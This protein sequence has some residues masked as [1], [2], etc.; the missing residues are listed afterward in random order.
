MRIATFLGCILI[1]G[2]CGTLHATPKQ[3]AVLDIDVGPPHLVVSVVD[4]ETVYTQRGPQKLKLK[5]PA[6][7]C[8]RTGRDGYLEK[9]ACP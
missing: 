4:G 3:S 5:A 8:L 9:F 7:V 1:W 6:G 2:C